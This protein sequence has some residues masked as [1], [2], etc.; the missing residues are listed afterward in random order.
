L[1]ALKRERRL[2]DLKLVKVGG[3]GGSEAPRGVFARQRLHLLPS[4]VWLYVK[5]NL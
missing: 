3:P 4:A 5:R 1:A 2:S